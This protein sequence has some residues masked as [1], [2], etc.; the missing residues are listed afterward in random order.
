[1][2]KQYGQD[3]PPQL[4]S[5]TVEIAQSDLLA[6]QRHAGFEYLLNIEACW[7]RNVHCPCG[8]DQFHI[9]Y[10]D[11]SV[12]HWISGELAGNQRVCLQCTGCQRS[13]LLFDDG[14]HGYNAVVCD[15]RGSLPHNYLPG[16]AALLR[17]S[18]CPCGN[19]RLRVFV[20]A[21]YDCYS[22]GELVDLPEDQWDDAYGYFLAVA[23]CPTC[24]GLH[25]VASAETA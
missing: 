12:E 7:R 11:S 19:S 16:N 23:Y 4:R 20:A 8:H 9:S 5:L 22:A 2:S 13:Y 14:L 21:V 24:L 17:P 15:D 3:G 10:A 25:E 18:L 1:M 6:L